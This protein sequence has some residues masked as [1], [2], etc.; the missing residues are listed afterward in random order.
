MKTT[1]KSLSL[2]LLLIL[3][4]ITWTYTQEIEVTNSRV[5][6][7][8][9][10]THGYLMFYESGDLLLEKSN[11]GTAFTINIHDENY[12]AFA[13]RTNWG[14]PASF[15]VYGDGTAFL[16]STA[17]TSDSTLKRN[18]T[19]LGPQIENVK[20]LNGVSFNWKGKSL[21]GDKLSYGLL[22]Q[23]LEKV[24]P[25][26]VFSNDS[27]VKAI[28]YDELIAVLIEAFNEQQAMIEE[29]QADVATLKKQAG[30]LKSASALP[31]V[32]DQTGSK[33]ELYQNV[34]NP[35]TKNTR[36]DY[37]LTDDVKNAAIAIYNLN[38]TQLKSIPLHLKGNGNVIIYGNELKAGMYLYALIADEKVIDT[39][40]MVL[41]D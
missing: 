11:S 7:R 5:Y 20:K 40:R 1:I 26:M 23:D 15:S 29:L 17:V 9:Q 16:H 6:L 39:K 3:T 2:T 32:N 35:F 28:Y 25:D 33:N 12:Q 38:G 21:K 13:V 18:I 14:T 22:A 10:D 36:I 37:F 31:G 8:S 41:T 19:E 30:N 34:P 4:N 24:Y 27:G